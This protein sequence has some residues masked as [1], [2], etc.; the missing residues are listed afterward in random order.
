M[1]RAS[2]S[3]GQIGL[4]RMALLAAYPQKPLEG[5]LKAFEGYLKAFEWYLKAL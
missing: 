5:Y 3:I 4:L 2:W 1:G